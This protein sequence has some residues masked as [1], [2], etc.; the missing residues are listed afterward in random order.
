MT[1]YVLVAA[2]ALFGDL[3]LLLAMY[4]VYRRGIALILAGV[5]S[6]VVDV[7]GLV[8]FVL[9]REGITLERVAVAMVVLV[10]IIVGLL[11]WMARRVINPARRMAEAAR[12]IAEAD[13]TRFTE[14]AAAL[15]RGE[16]PA[17][18]SLRS[19]TLSLAQADEL[20]ELAQ[21]FNHMIVQLQEANQAFRVM[22][23]RLA[24]VID[25]A[26]RIGQG[27]LTVSVRPQSERDLLGQAFARM[28]VN[29]KE[30]AGASRQGAA[31]I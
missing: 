11:M 10:P 29:L 18:I 28:V 6:G 21:A 4:L 30:M 17:S 7:I 31:G 25:A 9:G 27:D 26:D 13:L 23:D 1:E 16:R 3:V 5:V 14:T 12:L 19:Q 22:M 2:T 20:G 24:E 8:A 15:A